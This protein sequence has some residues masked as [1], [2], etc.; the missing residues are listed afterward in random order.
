MR[1]DNDA[2]DLKDE[3]IKDLVLYILIFGVIA[4]GSY[5]YFFYPAGL[6]NE[7]SDWGA[8][9][10]YFNGMLSPIIGF[11]TIVLIYRTYEFQKKE[12]K[13]TRS[14]LNEQV[15]QAKNAA[16]REMLWK[17]AEEVYREIVSSFLEDKN[18]FSE[19]KFI[20]QLLRSGYETD[21]R[22]AETRLGLYLPLITELND[23]LD[24]IDELVESDSRSTNY[25]RRRI[26]QYFKPFSDVLN[27]DELS[28]VINFYES[29][30]ISKSTD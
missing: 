22:N 6:S 9:G 13:E 10:D 24:A 28:R 23:Y 19:S 8:L 17:S 1:S 20:E 5:A 7:T 4:L 18:N 16:K 26:L 12:L 15:T 14:A 25:F 3:R 11:V 30:I 2:Y 21:K 27:I 29:K